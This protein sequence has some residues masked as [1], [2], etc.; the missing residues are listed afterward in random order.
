VT[1]KTVIPPIPEAR[2]LIVDDELHVCSALAR[3]LMLMGY[4][5]DKAGSGRE[6]LGILERTPYDL[7]VLDMR[8]PG[9]DGIE[10][11]HRA[12]QMQPDLLIIV[13]TGHATLE[14][15]ITAVKC[16][17]VDYLLKPASVH[18]IAAVAADALQRRAEKLRRQ[19]LLRVMGQALDEMHGIETTAGSS[20]MP[21]LER[22]LRAGPV[23]LDQ[24]KRLAVVGGGDDADS[25]SAE[26]TATE[27]ALLAYLV[28][29]SGTVLSCR[30]LARAVLSYD[31]SEREAQNIVRPHISR[32]RKK[33]DPTPPYRLIRT[34]TG[35]G[36]IFSP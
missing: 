10:V 29:H 27:T 1:D 13:L 11:M 24:E 28:Q 36:Y 31:V 25:R 30:E 12:H 22:F 19:H 7:M 9:M 4:R 26:L 14:S 15:A 16:G 35:K 23:T 17:A 18:E 2:M 20:P 5:A 8:M 34:V 3:S 32:L 21:S 6:A 33:V